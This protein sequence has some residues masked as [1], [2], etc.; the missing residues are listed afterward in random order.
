MG[1]GYYFCIGVN[2]L[3]ADH[4]GNTYEPLLGAENDAIEME[5]LATAAGF[6][7]LCGKSPRL[8]GCAAKYPA[9]KACLDSIPTRVGKDDLVLVSFA[10]HG[11]R[12]TR[13][14]LSQLKETSTETWCLFDTEL[15][16]LELGELWTHIAPE[17]RVL[18]ISD[19]CNSGTIVSIPPALRPNRGSRR[20]ESLG[21]R[22]HMRLSSEAQAAALAS[23]KADYEERVGRVLGREEARR[24]T[25]ARLL[26]L[27]AC[28][29]VGDAVDA[30]P[31]SAYP[32]MLFSEMLL[33]TWSAGTNRHTYE[34][35]MAEVRASVMKVEPAQK[36]DIYPLPDD[37]VFA[38]QRPF[39]L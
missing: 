18:V 7:P 2:Q 16:D 24:N 33:A 26:L 23:G 32:L 27:A 17:A 19:S 10:G 1:T 31:H 3:S 14:D 29:E 22:A 9:V 37:R 4:Y 36:P 28:A 38:S 39:S 35:F 21:R 8:L 34:E 15:F 13:G 6:V 11:G 30:D 25:R 5:K 12:Y 20:L